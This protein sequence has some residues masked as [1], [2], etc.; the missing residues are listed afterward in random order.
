MRRLTVALLFVAAAA[1]GSSSPPVAPSPVTQTPVTPPPPPPPVILTGRVVA[2]VTGEAL[3]GLSVLLADKATPTDADGRFRYELPPGTVA[4][5]RLTV[6]GVGIVSHSLSLS[7][8]GSRDVSLDAISLSGGVDLDY[9]RQLVRNA[10]DEPET[11]QP[12]R[13][14]TQAPHVY[15]KTVD[16]AGQPIEADTLEP[17]AAALVDDAAAWTGGRF[18]IAD[19]ERGTETREGVRGWITVKWPATNDPEVCGRALIAVSGGWIELNYRNDLCACTHSRVDPGT[20][21]HELGHAM[22]FYHTRERSDVMYPIQN[23]CDLH[24]SARERLHAAIAYGRPN[25]NT[26]PDDDP[27]LLFQRYQPSAPIVIVN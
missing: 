13:R 23:G 2:S 4:T 8:Q 22:G 21:R 18:G 3:G 26:D 19:V 9:Y 15:L 10:Y 25:G 16:E 6:S 14:W 20:V 11:L 12:L 1:C 5:P 24:P 17:V 7:I 27:M